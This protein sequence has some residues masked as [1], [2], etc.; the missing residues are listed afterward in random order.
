MKV[1]EASLRYVVAMAFARTSA[2]DGQ[3]G[4]FGLLFGKK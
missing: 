3:G 1:Y 4:D 2:N